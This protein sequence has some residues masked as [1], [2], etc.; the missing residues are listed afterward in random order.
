MT[1]VKIACKRAAACLVLEIEPERIEIIG[2]HFEVFVDGKK[3]RMSATNEMS[4]LA[5]TAVGATLVPGS[6]GDPNLCDDLVGSYKY[7]LRVLENL[8][9]PTFAL[10]DRLIKDGR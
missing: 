5:L 2:P 10:A 8:L 6:H 9:F 7:L 3:R 1:D 4:I